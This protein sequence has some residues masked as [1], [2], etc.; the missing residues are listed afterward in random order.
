[1]L[2]INRDGQIPTSGPTE[3]LVRF[4][5]DGDGSREAIT[6]TATTNPDPF[7]WLDLNQNGRVDSGR[8]LFG[9]ATSHPIDE[10]ETRH[11][12]V[13]LAWYDSLRLGGNGDGLISP[14]DEVWSHLVLWTDLDHDAIADRG[15]T[16]QLSA[17]G[18][19]ALGLDYWFDLHV[20]SSG[21]GHL[22]KSEYKRRE[23]FAEIHDLFFQ[24][25]R[26]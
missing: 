13:A 26:E 23:G 12:F 1:V 3:N 6:W 21:N 14:A 4:D 25:L 5:L 22:F 8:E 18:V 19:L 11:G 17:S 20:D 7:L 16:L 24:I 15:E 10:N 2:D 9:D